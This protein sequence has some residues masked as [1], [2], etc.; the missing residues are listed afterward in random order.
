M[1]IYPEHRAGLDKVFARIHI[2]NANPKSGE[3]S[4]NFFASY[5]IKSQ[6]EK[7]AIL[8]SPHDLSS[9]ISDLKVLVDLNYDAMFK[10]TQ[11]NNGEQIQKYLEITGTSGVTRDRETI[12]SFVQIDALFDK[13][14]FPEE[15]EPKE[16][17]FGI[18]SNSCL[19]VLA[20]FRARLQILNDDMASIKF[21]Q[22][23]DQP[24]SFQMSLKSGN[25]KTSV[26]NRGYPARLRD[27]KEAA[28]KYQVKLKREV[29]LKF[30]SILKLQG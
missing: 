23:P 25:M 4:Q 3:S 28:R 21:K 16:I 20:K 12:R 15:I 19:N 1:I 2:N 24:N 26:T 10:L 11:C 13:S 30:F 17:E 7:S 6:K 22:R 5:Q 29:F 18:D 9:F 8:I 14:L 27:E